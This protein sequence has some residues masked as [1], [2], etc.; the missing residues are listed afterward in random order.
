MAKAQHNQHRA[1]LG[2]PD[3]Q[4]KSRGAEHNMAGR[5]AKSLSFYDPKL[6]ES[7]AEEQ[8]NPLQ[9]QVYFEKAKSIISQNNSPDI[10]FNY[11]IN[12]Y[13]GCE[14]GC[15]YCFA[16]PTHSYLDLSPGLDFEAKLFVKENAPQLLVE[17]LSHPNYRSEHLALGVNTD[18]YQPIEKQFQLTRR[19]LEICLAF[20]QPVSVVT[21]GT[22]LLRDLDLL[23]ELNKHQLV[24][25][26]I[27]MT[28]LNNQ[29]KAAME[30]R[31]A[32]VQSRLRI[33]KA[34]VDHNIPVSVLMA[35]IIPK[36][37]DHEL[38]AIL[39]TVADL[40]VTNA[41]YVM[42]RLPHELAELFNDW[43]AAHF[44]LKAQAIMNMMR[45]CHQGEIYRSGFG[46]RQTGSGRFAE[47]IQQRFSITA[48]QLGLNRKRSIPKNHSDFSIPKN[49]HPLLELM[50][51]QKE[52]QANTARSGRQMSLF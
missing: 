49:L 2:I 38:E 26:A 23:I 14:H 8:S 50:D 10:H 5:F 25:V 36:L 51:W 19:I 29:L 35:P 31:A 13:R 1:V 18:C 11:S 34:L 6:I 28:T 37:N 48:K 43:L 42:L 52:R 33:I 15:S 41:G 12:P 3:T 20:K 7:Q 9:T 21:K 4:I 16:R 45:A 46:V 40:G 17:A 32:G 39:K 27:S 24:S 44:P 22:L 30:P 47:L